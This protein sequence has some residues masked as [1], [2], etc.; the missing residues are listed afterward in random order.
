MT[1]LRQ[2]IIAS[3]SL[4]FNRFDRTLKQIEFIT[5][6]KNLNMYKFKNLS[7]EKIIIMIKKANDFQII[8]NF[9]KIKFLTHES[10]KF[11]YILHQIHTYVLSQTNED[12]SRKLLIIEN[13]SLTTFFYQSVFNK[14]YIKSEILHVELLN[15]KRVNLIKKFNDFNDSL[16]ILIIMYQVSIQRINLNTCCSKMIVFT[17]TINVSFEIQ[18]WSRLIRICFIMN[19]YQYDESAMFF[20]REFVL[21]WLKR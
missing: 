9:E 20:C 2:F 14:L 11:R 7:V 17:S 13:I 5:L 10:L 18:A 3:S 1:F 19:S 21:I 4:I 12:R 15:M 16:L 6:I 8:T